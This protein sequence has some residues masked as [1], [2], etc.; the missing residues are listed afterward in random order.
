MS[1]RLSD[2]QW[3]IVAP[4]IARPPRLETRGRPRRP[5]REIL[6]A[7]LSLVRQWSSWRTASRDLAPYQTVFRRVRE[8]QECGILTRVLEALARDME[9]RGGVRLRDC[10]LDTA[11]EGIQGKNP[12]QYFIWFEDSSLAWDEDPFARPWPENIQRFF[13]EPRV[14]RFLRACRSPWIQERLPTDLSDRLRFV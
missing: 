5:D 9:E 6:E 8:W 11:F 12:K 1:L 10:F 14:W 7:A 2:E 4:I 13:E 3:A